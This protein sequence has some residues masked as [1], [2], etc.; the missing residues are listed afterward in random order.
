MT[1]KLSFKVGPNA[2]YKYYFSARV[3]SI[4]YISFNWKAQ[5][6]KRLKWLNHDT[7]NVDS[8]ATW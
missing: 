7:K 2:L 6:Q 4:D 5:A 1:K 8:E 3:I